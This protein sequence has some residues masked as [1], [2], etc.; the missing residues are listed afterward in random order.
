MHGY[1]EQLVT[2]VTCDQ[3]ELSWFKALLDYSSTAFHNLWLKGHFQIV[4]IRSYTVGEN[5]S[6]V[7]NA[8]FSKQKWIRE[9][10]NSPASGSRTA[11]TLDDR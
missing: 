9:A 2:L 10:R 1:F 8:A 5:D 7:K 4:S 6:L 3:N 11:V